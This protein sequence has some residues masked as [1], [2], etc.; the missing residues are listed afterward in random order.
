[1]KHKRFAITAGI[2]L[3]LLVFFILLNR[4]PVEQLDANAFDNNPQNFHLSVTNK[5]VSYWITLDP[6]ASDKWLF[7]SGGGL[8][9][10]NTPEP[11]ATVPL[12]LT[13]K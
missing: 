3:V 10:N 6:R 4:V 12:V 9:P 8:L 5:S 13:N 7:R 1:M 11:T 2:A